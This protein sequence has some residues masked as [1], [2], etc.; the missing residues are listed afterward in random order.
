MLF[1]ASEEPLLN[2][3]ILRQN[4]GE[5]VTLKR[6]QLP[7][8]KIPSNSCFTIMILRYT[9]VTLRFSGYASYKLVGSDLHP[10]NRYLDIG[11]RG[12]P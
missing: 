4:G 11:L 10:A 6:S 2:E 12:F 7:P 9:Y 5:L 3:T 8:S 1:F